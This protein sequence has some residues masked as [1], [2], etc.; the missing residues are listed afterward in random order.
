MLLALAS[1]AAP[2]PASAPPTTSPPTA[3]AGAAGTAT[4]AA[5]PNSCAI[6]LLNGR[7]RPGEDMQV[8]FTVRPDSQWCFDGIGLG[9]TITEGQAI[10]TP[11]A[12]GELRLVRQPGA[13]VFGYRPAPGFTGTDRFRISVPAQIATIYLAGNVTVGP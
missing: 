10:A 11:P 1:C 5:K 3:A 9:N 7:I 12:H 8:V 13:V 2:P 4:A 6:R